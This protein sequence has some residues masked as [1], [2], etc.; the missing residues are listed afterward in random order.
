[1]R[2]NPTARLALRLQPELLDPRASDLIATRGILVCPASHEL[3]RNG[4]WRFRAV[5]AA[6][7]ERRLS[8]GWRRV[9]FD[10]D[11][12]ADLGRYKWQR[13]SSQ[14]NKGQGDDGTARVN[15]ILAEEA[16]AAT[17]R[18]GGDRDSEPNRAGGANEATTR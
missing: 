11:G 18:T 4:V 16:T 3:A 9:P 14:G 6:V 1:M 12:V 2:R 15:A 10:P 8:A 5:I 13:R 17:E 7:R